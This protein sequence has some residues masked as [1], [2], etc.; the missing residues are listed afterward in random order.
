MTPAGDAP[1]RAQ[2]RDALHGKGQ[3]VDPTRMLEQLDWRLTGKRPGDAEHSIFKLVQHLNYW[4]EIQV[5]RVAGADRPSPPH[6]AEGWPGT[7]EPASEEEWRAA[8][9][10][11]RDLLGRAE[12]GAETGALGEPLPNW[13][14]RTRFEGLLGIALH[15]A[16]H[17][18]QIVQLR[19]MVGSWPPPGG[20]D[21]W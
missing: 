16:Y 20:G 18:G 4:L 15:N 21:T 2:L 8:V 10:R 17:A 19:K 3:F 6:D 13:G 11:F 7:Q 12:R 5:D 9:A 14:S 1:L